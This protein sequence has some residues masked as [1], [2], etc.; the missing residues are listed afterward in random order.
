KS[1]SNILEQPIKSWKVEL[2]NDFEAS[3]FPQ[4][5]VLAEIKQKLYGVGAVYAAMS[6]SGSCFFGVFEKQNINTKHFDDYLW[7]WVQTV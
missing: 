7:K 6:G 2:K 3:I 1:I 5:P 4:Y